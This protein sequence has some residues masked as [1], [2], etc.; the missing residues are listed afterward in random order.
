MFYTVNYKAEN[1]FLSLN[2]FM[3]FWGNMSYCEVRK[4]IENQWWVNIRKSSL[5]LRNSEL[6]KFL[7][8]KSITPAISKCAFQQVY[9]KYFNYRIGIIIFQTL[10]LVTQKRPELLFWNFLLKVLNEIFS[11]HLNHNSRKLT[12]R[13]KSPNTDLFVVCSF[14]YSDWIMRFT[15]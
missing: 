11:I 4:K 10:A 13:E 6:Y 15:E 1:F 12:L 8:Y 14:P 7:L 5:V 9:S 3:I 2:Y